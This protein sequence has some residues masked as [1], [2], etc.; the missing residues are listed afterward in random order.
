MTKKGIAIA[1]RILAAGG[2]ASMVKDRSMA[3]LRSF[4]GYLCYLPRD[5]AC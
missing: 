5:S 4:P 3:R 1:K 2:G